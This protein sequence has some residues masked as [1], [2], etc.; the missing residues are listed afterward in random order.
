MDIDELLLDDVEGE[1]AD[2]E[3]EELL[4]PVEPLVPLMPVVLP[5][6]LLEVL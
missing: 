1:V 6:V 5:V 3:E 4:E 2:D